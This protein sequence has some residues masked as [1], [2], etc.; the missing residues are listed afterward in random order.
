L[1]S[2]GAVTI[3]TLVVGSGVAAYRLGGPYGERFSERE[4]YIQRQFDTK[5]S[6]LRVFA[7]DQNRNGHMDAWTYL[8]EG[9]MLRTEVDENEDGLMDRWYY[10]GNGDD[11]I[12]RVGFSTRNNGRVDAWRRL[13]ADGEVAE[14]EYANGENGAITKREYFSSGTLVRTELFPTAP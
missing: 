3:A 2:I 4:A 10:Y 9:R 1:V 14:V 11:D 6:E 5:T 12:S 7:Y 13:N 8:L